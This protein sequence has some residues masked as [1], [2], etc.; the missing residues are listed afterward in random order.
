MPLDESAITAIEQAYP[1]VRF[2]WTRILEARPAPRRAERSP[3]AP[4]HAA[5][6]GEG[7][8]RDRRTLRRRRPSP[9]QPDPDTAEKAG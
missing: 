2:D 6:S 7:R 3:D 9:G 5:R 8:S 1:D 4:S